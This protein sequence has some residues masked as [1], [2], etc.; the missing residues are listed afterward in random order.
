MEKIK[1]IIKRANQNPEITEIDSTL[2][3]LQNIVKGNIEM[4]PFPNIKNVS[5]ILNEEGKLD[6]LDPTLIT[7]EYGDILVGNLIIA[8]ICRGE[9]VSL[10]DNQIKKCNTYLQKNQIIDM[11]I[12]EAYNAMRQFS[13]SK[14]NKEMEA[15]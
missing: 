6:G 13:D 4:I 7:P 12:Y 5:I 15:E 10:T 1:V 9:T 2:K 14:R 3:T 8:G 11:D